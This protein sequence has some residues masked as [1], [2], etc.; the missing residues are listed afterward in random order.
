VFIFGFIQLGANFVSHVPVAALAGVT[1]YVGICLLD[2]STWHRLPKMR[3]SDA[4]AF[5]V[6]AVAVLAVNA[7][8]AVALGCS[9]YAVRWAVYRFRPTPPLQPADESV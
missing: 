6:T 1:A 8:A 3:R 5:L 9:V 4:A 7:V 2:W